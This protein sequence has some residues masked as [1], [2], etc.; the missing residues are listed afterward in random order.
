MWQFENKISISNSKNIGSMRFYFQNF[1]IKTFVSNLSYLL[2]VKGLI[3]ITIRLNYCDSDWPSCIGLLGIWQVWTK[4]SFNTFPVTLVSDL[5]HSFS[6][7]QFDTNFL[8]QFK[9]SKTSHIISLGIVPKKLMY[10]IQ[11][12]QIAERY[13]VLNFDWALAVKVLIS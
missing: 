12:I 6:L 9:T 7:W 10:H 11:D 8:W 1:H 2:A 5:L 13:D 4:M 3:F